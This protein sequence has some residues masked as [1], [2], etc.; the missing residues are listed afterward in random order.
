MLSVRPHFSYIAKQNKLKRMFATCET[1]GQVEWIMDDSCLV[2]SYLVSLILNEF[3]TSE[4]FFHTCKK[5]YFYF[6]KKKHFCM[7]DRG[8]YF[9]FCLC[10]SASENNSIF[11]KR[12]TCNLPQII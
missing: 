5:Y 8:D 1:V 6:Q 9:F 4:G 3:P 11:T 10:L 7:M 2:N 12:E